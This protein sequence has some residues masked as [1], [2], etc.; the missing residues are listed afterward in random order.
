MRTSDSRPYHQVGLNLLAVGLS[1]IGL[2]RAPL[3][4]GAFAN[5]PAAGAAASS[6]PAQNSTDPA[7]FQQLLH[8]YRPGRA[9]DAINALAGWPVDRL[10]AAAKASTPN[11]SSSDRMA[12]ADLYAEVANALLVVSWPNVSS[13]EGSDAGIRQTREVLKVINSALALLHHAGARTV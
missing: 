1:V 8:N 7:A 5:A 3:N 4:E 6:V 11:L 13:P 12:A 9:S 10:T 2:S